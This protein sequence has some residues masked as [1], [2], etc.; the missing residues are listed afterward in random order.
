MVGNSLNQ[1]R[2]HNNHLEWYNMDLL[3]ITS[4]GK[5]ISAWSRKFQITHPKIQVGYIQARCLLLRLDVSHSLQLENFFS[6]AGTKLNIYRVIPGS[7]K[8][9][10]CK[11]ME[12]WHW[13]SKIPYVKFRENTHQANFSSKLLPYI[14]AQNG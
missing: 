10:L 6:L 12:R 9:Y 4:E 2:H 14:I 11:N 7:F 8:T 13:L 1:R 3:V 5:F